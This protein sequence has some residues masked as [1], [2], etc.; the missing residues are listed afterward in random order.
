[1]NGKTTK[2]FKQRKKKMMFLRVRKEKVT[3][4]TSMND[5]Q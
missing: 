1:M 4:K 3:L 5:N 2:K